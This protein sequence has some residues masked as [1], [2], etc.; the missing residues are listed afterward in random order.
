M[1]GY[2][3]LNEANS[4]IGYG[5]FSSYVVIFN[6][7]ESFPKS[8]LNMNTKNHCAQNRFTFWISL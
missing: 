4:Q 2:D 7:L 5:F 1:V 3:L 6:C 8:K